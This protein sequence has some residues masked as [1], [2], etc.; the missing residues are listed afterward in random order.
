MKRNI[1]DSLP[2]EIEEGSNS[3]NASESADNAST[4]TTSDRLSRASTTKGCA[5]AEITRTETAAVK[6]H[7]LLV[8]FALCVAAA[9]VG[10]VTYLLME[11]EETA[12]YMS[13]VSDS[14]LCSHV[15][16]QLIL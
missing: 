12:N 11:N 9:A 8:Y 5:I 1:G 10:A 14:F 6:R 4:S 2:A 16:C 3:E 7:K 13:D 15:L